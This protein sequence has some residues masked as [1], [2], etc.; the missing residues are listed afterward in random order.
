MCSVNLSCTARDSAQTLISATHR[1]RDDHGRLTW[2]EERI[3]AH[4]VEANEMQRNGGIK[5]SDI[6]A[7]WAILIQELAYDVVS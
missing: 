3:S 6:V 7:A 2:S 1:R 4:V 5:P